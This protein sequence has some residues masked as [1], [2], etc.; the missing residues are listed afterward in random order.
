M[1]PKEV[2]DVATIHCSVCKMVVPKSNSC[3]VVSKHAESV[4]S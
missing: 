1:A 4:Y 2:D 3:D